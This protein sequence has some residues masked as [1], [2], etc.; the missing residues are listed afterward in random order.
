MCPAVINSVDRCKRDLIDV[1]LRLEVKKIMVHPAFRKD[2][3][4]KMVSTVVEDSGNKL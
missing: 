1:S 3:S 2:K 4:N